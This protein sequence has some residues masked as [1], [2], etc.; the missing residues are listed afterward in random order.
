MSMAQAHSAAAPPP[1]RDCWWCFAIGSTAT[2]WQLAARQ[3]R[4]LRYGALRRGGMASAG[5]TN[6]PVARHWSP[7]SR[8]L[9]IRSMKKTIPGEWV[10]YGEGVPRS[11]ALTRL[12]RC[13][14]GEAHQCLP[15]DPGMPKTPK[16]PS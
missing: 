16:H 14:C 10:R 13:H 9:Y 15:R 11:A 8:W 3:A 1:V 4:L 7:T 12:R 2:G 6:I 5:A